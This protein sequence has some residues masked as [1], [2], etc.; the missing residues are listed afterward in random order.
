[1]RLYDFFYIEDLGCFKM[2]ESLI[3]II[4]KEDMDIEDKLIVP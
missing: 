4:K 2:R 1:M 3:N